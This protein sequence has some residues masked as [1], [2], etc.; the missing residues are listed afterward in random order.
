MYLVKRQS[1]AS[2]RDCGEEVPGRSYQKWTARTFGGPC[3]PETT[4]VER[5][6]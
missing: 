3:A 5:T 2:L 6:T 4:L 1:G